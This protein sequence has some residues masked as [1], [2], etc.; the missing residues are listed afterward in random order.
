LP[1]NAGDTFFIYVDGYMGDAAY[2]LDV[3]FEPLAPVCNAATT[4]TL[5]DTNGN[6]TPGSAALSSTC[7]GGGKELVYTFTPAASGMLNLT[8]ASASDQGIHVRTDC[9]DS[10]SEI[11]CADLNLGGTNETLAVPVTNGMAVTITVDAYSPG[12]EGPFTLTL[13]QP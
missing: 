11:G 2:S 13:A 3:S 9:L 1:V 10:T 7:G 5:G 6:T 12:E 4:I 8:L